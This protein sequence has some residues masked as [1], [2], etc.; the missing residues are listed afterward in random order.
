MHL[1]VGKKVGR[2]VFKKHPNKTSDSLLV[3]LALG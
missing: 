3:A 1:I 2:D